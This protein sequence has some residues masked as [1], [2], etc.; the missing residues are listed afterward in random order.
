M[1]EDEILELT[2]KYENISENRFR[3]HID[4]QLQSCRPEKEK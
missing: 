3:S 1:L 4:L 2:E